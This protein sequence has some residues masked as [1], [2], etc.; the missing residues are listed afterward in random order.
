MEENETVKAFGRAETLIKASFASFNL[1]DKWTE[2]QSALSSALNK[3]VERMK[4][5][6]SL[7]TKSST[8]KDRK[9]VT[10]NISIHEGSPN[11]AKI[12]NASVEE[13]STTRLLA[14]RWSAANVLSPSDVQRAR[15]DGA[16]YLKGDEG[17]F[18]ILPLHSKLSEI[19][20][21]KTEISLHL[22]L[23]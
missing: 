4:Q 12:G 8:S 16:F 3:D 20:A 18:T 10:V 23:A 15:R 2:N 21:E 13:E 17:Q 14:L 6:N 19:A 7:L 5:L 1:S 22:V 11:R 9:V